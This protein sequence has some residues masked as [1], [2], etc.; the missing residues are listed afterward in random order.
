MLSK[1]CFKCEEEKPIE[2]FYRHPR[3]KDGHLGKCKACAKS[4]SIQHRLSN[5]AKCRAY[6]IERFALPHRKISVAKV[7]TRWRQQDSR[8]M[9]CHNAVTR[10]IRAGKLS[11]QNCCICGAIKA[12]AHHESYDKPLEVIW[13]CQVHHKERHKKMTEQGI[14]PF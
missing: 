10:A 11:K 3:M 12:Y 4:Y 13:Y 5:L 1:I 8:I 6:D 7:T 9:K 2:E 14:S